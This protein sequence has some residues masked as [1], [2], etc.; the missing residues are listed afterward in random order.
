[1]ST[2]RDPSPLQ[3]LLA[4]S[5]GRRVIGPFVLLRQLG[6]GGFAPVWLAREM[7]GDTE[8]RLVAV[9]L[10]SVADRHRSVSD[11]PSLRDRVIEE[12][13]LLCRVEHPNIV[14]FHALALDDDRG[15]VGLA[16][17][18]VGGTS[19]DHRLE[20]G[21]PPLDDTLTIG[22]SI[23][24]ALAA[25][26]RSGLVHR[27][28]K[29][30]NV[31][32]AGGIYKL[33][34]FGIAASEQPASAAPAPDTPRVVVLDDLPL[35]VARSR[36]SE[37]MG[38]AT[39]G[40]SG[41]Q[42]VVTGTVGYIDPVVMSTRAPAV[43]AS[44]LYGLGALL[45]ECLTGRLPAA[46][47]AGEG[48]RGE[49][50]DGRSSP[51][52]VRSLAPDAP[53]SLVA[54]VDA[55]LAP[56]R[57][58]RP[59]SAEWVSRELERI[60][61][62][63][64]GRRRAL[65]PE[66][67]GPFRG[68]ARFES[69]HRDVY[70]GRT[71]EVAGALEM[72]R[73]RGLAALIGP[74]G[75]GKSSLAR[76][77]IVPAVLGGALGTWPREWDLVVV[78]PG[79]DPRKTLS[80]ALSEIVPGAEGMSADEV[81][82]RLA[83][84]VQQTL[85]GVFLVVDQLEE[86]A[87]VAHGDSQ[88]WM[89]DVL[90]R[91][92]EE[93]IPGLRTLATVRQDL[94]DAVLRL[95]ALGR[96]LGRGS[97]LVVT[98]LT[99][100][101]WIDVVDQALA[102]YGYSPEDAVLRAELLTQ[103]SGTATA[104]PLVQFALTQL[105]EQRDRTNKQITWNALYSIGGIA[106]ALERHADATVQSL[107]AANPTVMPVVKRVLMALTTAQ[108]TRVAMGERELVTVGASPIA[109]AVIERLEHAR[110]IARD[111]DGLTLSHEALLTQWRLLASWVAEAREDRLLAEDVERD[112]GRWTD[113]PETP[114]WQKRRLMMAEDLARRGAVRLS[115]RA[116][117]FVEASGSARRR[118]RAVVLAAAVTAAGVGAAGLATYVREI[119]VR[120]QRIREEHQS[121]EDN[122]RAAESA[123]READARALDATG[124]M[125]QSDE[126]REK[127]RR[128]GGDIQQ[129]LE[130]LQEAASHARTPLELEEIRKKAR[131]LGAMAASA[132]AVPAEAPPP[133]ASSAPSPVASAPEPE[134]AKPRVVSNDVQ[135]AV[136][137]AA[138]QATATCLKPALEAAGPLA[139]PIQVRV[140]LGLQ[141]GKVVSVMAFASPGYP[142]VGACVEGVFRAR[143]YPAAEGAM[144]LRPLLYLAR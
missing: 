59:R 20:S 45:F 55:L 121:A 65:P 26:H 135:A 75:S 11:A 9:K 35:D 84:R 21:I 71:V 29:P 115:T 56:D 54:L 64:G 3:S 42:T 48:L 68:L 113:D 40:G 87:T 94:L 66:D 118:G 2:Q 82:G 31:I 80:A 77:G 53:P 90:A 134:K 137:A 128:L 22:V 58:A 140:H 117:A 95:S 104:M 110:I 130:A 60:R 129:R 67:V 92:G 139:S 96:A 43:P 83:E 102:A 70:F 15:L 46:A 103:L 97:L 4:G 101:A 136:D 116:E 126:Y 81:V 61:A 49:I 127:L 19:L 44:D 14:R 88:R 144:V 51:P 132:S 52:S 133:A 1:M 93:T 28:V 32:D 112:A 131:E 62:E 57:A 99:D 109:P 142:A 143:S 72:I 124:A 37:L 91:L 39:I 89:V 23:A 5:E 18:Y 10:F 8:L 33:I 114:L 73:S 63:L 85:R 138:A 25:V 119:G 76:A 107:A 27:D 108:A 79:D 36:A 17:E 30:A 120:E 100:E 105:W 38:A 98:P 69:E 16:M 47:N 74:S 13:R 12:A 111:G 34:D 78:S 122:R 123:K 141:D 86:I 125:A 24:S 106:G 50:L 41:R 7:Y 6:R